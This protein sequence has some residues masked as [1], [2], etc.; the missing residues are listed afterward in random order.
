MNAGGR[1]THHAWTRTRTRWSGW[2]RWRRAR[3]AG[4]WRVESRAC[5]ITRRMV[6][7]I[8]RVCVG[9]CGC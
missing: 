6:R 1:F 3:W 7:C 5:G 4:V 9:R 2:R 8:P